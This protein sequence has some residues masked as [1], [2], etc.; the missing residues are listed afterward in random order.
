M[1]NEIIL[2]YLQVTKP[3]FQDN[4]NQRVACRQDGFVMQPG[5]RLGNERLVHRR[6]AASEVEGRDQIDTA[7]G[8]AVGK[9]SILSQAV[10][11]IEKS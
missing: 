3:P 4:P 6:A 2:R 8:G 11:R 10:G 5:A 1:T 7:I 9:R